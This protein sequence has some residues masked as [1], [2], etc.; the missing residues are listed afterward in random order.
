MR[1][2]NALVEEADEGPY[3]TVILLTVFRPLYGKTISD[4][5]QGGGVETS[6]HNITSYLI[7]FENLY[8]QWMPA[9]H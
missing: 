9:V 2:F 6:T 7:F 8:P 5:P 1:F 3:M 4:F